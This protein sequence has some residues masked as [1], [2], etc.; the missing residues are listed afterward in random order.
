V[1]LLFEHLGRSNATSSA[2][3]ASMAT[4]LEGPETKDEIGMVLPP[5]GSTETSGLVVEDRCTIHGI[6]TPHLRRCDVAVVVAPSDRR[7]EAVALSTAALSFRRPKGLDPAAGLA[8]VSGDVPLVEVAWTAAVD[9]PA[10]LALGQRALGHEMVGLSRAMLEMARQH[11][12][13]RVQF[14]RPIGSFQAVR[15]RLADSLV[16]IQAADALL[17][18]AWDEPTSVNASI[19]KAFAGRSTQLTGRHCQQVLAGVGFTREHPFHRYLRRAMT[20][21]HLL[22]ASATLTRRLGS[23][24]IKTGRLPPA[25]AL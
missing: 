22:G 8:E 17:A 4:F 6:A 10:A 20:L 9:W 3:D 13:D 14:G 18:V 15:H 2:V 1:P 12:V 11:A 7:F 23:E 5:L 21:D 25:I 19:A 24:A 16:A